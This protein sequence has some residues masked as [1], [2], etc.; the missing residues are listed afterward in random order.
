LGLIEQWGSGIQRMMAACHDVG[1]A[2]PTF[3]EIGTRFRVTLWLERVGAPAI[4]DTERAILDVLRD[5]TG[6]MTSEIAKR[7]VSHHGPLARAFC[8]SWNVGLFARWAQA[9]RIQSGGI[10]YRTEH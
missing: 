9:H 5:G 4:D 3:E 1:L 8:G 6:H 7:S 10:F 2:P